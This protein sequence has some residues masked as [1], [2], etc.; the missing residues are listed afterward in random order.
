MSDGE[1]VA[2]YLIGQALCAPDSA[3]LIIDEPE[4]HLHASLRGRLWDAIESVRTDCTFVYITHN[5]D[6]A[7]ERTNA[8]TIWVESYDGSNWRWQEVNDNED[9]PAALTLEILGSRKPILF[10]EGEADSIDPAVYRTLFPD[11]RVIPRGCCFSVIR[12]VRAVNEPGVFPNQTAYG[13]IDRDRRSSQELDAL[14]RDNIFAC[15]VAEVENLLC[16]P[17]ALE[18]ASASVRAPEKAAEAKA[19]AIREFRKESEIDRHAV[20]FAYK[21]VHFQLGRFAEEKRWSKDDLVDAYETHLSAIS[22]EDCFSEE[23]ERLSQIA[24]RGD[25]VEILQVFNRKGLV[26]Q[27]AEILGLKPAAY[28]EFVFRTLEDEHQNGTVGGLLDA[29]RVHLP[30]IPAE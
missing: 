9:L 24:S 2:F 7:A 17:E 20:A 25:Y 28:R 11:H 30:T 14:V 22:V 8:E 26:N 19:F 5:L 6:F 21:S 29:I 13:L 4:I 27:L 10:V 3:V 1:R 23:R 16:L 15:P 18:V 12:S